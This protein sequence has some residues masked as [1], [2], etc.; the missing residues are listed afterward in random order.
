MVF[1]SGTLA[2]QVAAPLIAVGSIAG[3]LLS[4]RQVWPSLDLRRAGPMVGG[5]LVGVPIGV[6]LLPLVDA[7]AFRLGVGV[8]LCVYCPAMLMLGR[9]P[10]VHWGGR[11]A[12]AA[13]GLAGGVMGGLAGLAGPAPILWCTLRGWDRDTQRAMFQTFLL[14]A[15]AGALV[16][17][18][19]AGLL[20]AEVFRLAAWVL[21]C[22]LLPSFLGTLV[23][24]RLGGEAFRRLVLVVL[25]ATG[26]VLVA[27]GVLAGR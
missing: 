6:V 11:A 22:I 20:T 25:L 10:R 18:A 27:R 21:P 2:P 3:Q 15:Q 8:M 14:V 9:L 1:W 4:I 12:D 13:A 19:A 26:A 17:F 7:G 24:S 23:Y 5:G 16:A